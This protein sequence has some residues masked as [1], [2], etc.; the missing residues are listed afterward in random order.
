MRTLLI[1]VGLAFGSGAIQSRGAETCYLQGEEI[2]G[3]NKVCYYTCPS[4]RAAITIQAH[5][6]CPLSIKR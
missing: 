1:V 3:L 6:L 5:H 2:S 4:G